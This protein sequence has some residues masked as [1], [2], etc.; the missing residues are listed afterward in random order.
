MYPDIVHGWAIAERHLSE[1]AFL[2]ARLGA[3][4]RSPRHTLADAVEQE[5]RLRAHLDGLLIEGHGP[6]P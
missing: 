4:F 6:R 3:I 5:Q 2:W 1:A